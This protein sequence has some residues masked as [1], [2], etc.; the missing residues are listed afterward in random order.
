MACGTKK[1]GGKKPPKKSR[2]TSIKGR[3]DIGSN[4]VEALRHN[5]EWRKTS[6]M[7]PNLRWVRRRS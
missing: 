3:L 7:A 2:P 1:T 5:A 4:P 6:K